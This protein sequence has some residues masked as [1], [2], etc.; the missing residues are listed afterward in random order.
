VEGPEG[1][2]VKHSPG[3]KSVTINKQELMNN[4]LSAGHT[5]Y[6]TFAVALAALALLVGCHS[7]MYDQPRGKP[8]VWSRFFP[9]RREARPLVDG[10]VPH[11]DTTESDLLLTGKLDGRVSDTFPFRVTKDVLERGHERYNIYC[12]PCHGLLGDGKGMVVRRGFPPPPSF[13]SDSLRAKPVGHYVDVITHGLGKMFPY[14][15]RV[16]P[17]DRWAIAAYIRAL[18]LSQNAPVR[19]LSASQRRPLTGE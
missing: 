6:V 10:T 8:L 5:K 4:D 7:D 9:D 1:L 19:D 12:S 11:S 13:H 18:Q 16:Q 14:A 15:D 3:R 17:H 2:G